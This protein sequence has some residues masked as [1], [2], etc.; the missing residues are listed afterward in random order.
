MT[1]I[2][3]QTGPLGAALR[4][5]PS[6]DAPVVLHLP[7]GTIL[8]GELVHGEELYG[9]NRYLALFVWMGRMVDVVEDVPA[10]RGGKRK[11]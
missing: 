7:E 3:R 6:A 4:D 9:D 5:A 11:M 8:E 2:R 1:T 10:R